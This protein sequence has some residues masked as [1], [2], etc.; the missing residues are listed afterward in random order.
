[1]QF[2]TI[3]PNGKPIVTRE[4][5]ELRRES[6][7]SRATDAQVKLLESLFVDNYLDFGGS[8]LMD[9]A[10]REIANESGSGWVPINVASDRRAGANW[11][12]WRTQQEL[13]GLRAKS[14][15]VVATNSYAKG[16][17]RNLTSHVIGKGNTYKV[18]PKDSAMP[19]PD[20]ANPNAQAPNL[21]PLVDATQA[22]VDA[23]LKSN[24][25]NCAADPM[26]PSK[27]G[28][29]REQE[30]YR[31]VKR[32]GEAILQFFFL[33]GR[34]Q[35]GRG[36]VDRGKT[37]V[38]FIEPACIVDPPGAT[39]Q[40]GWFLGLRHRV[41][42]YEDLEDVLEYHVLYSDPTL[43]NVEQTESPMGK[44]I[45]AAEIVHITNPD[46]DAMLGR[47]TP[48]FVYDTFKAFYRA[49]KLQQ[50]ISLGATIRACTAEMWEWQLATQQ[51]IG[52]LAGGQGT[53]KQNQQTGATEYNQKVEPGMIRHGPA[54][55]KLVPPVQGMVQE[56]L[57]AAQ[58]DLRQAASAGC[59]PEYMVSADASNA[60]YASTKEAGTPFVRYAELEQEYF[61]G[62]F[63]ACIWKAVWWAV[64]CGNLPKEALTLLDI[65]VK[66]A[67]VMTRDSLEVAQEDQ[68]LI[69]AG[70]KDRATASA[71]RGY[72]PDSVEQANAEYQQKNGGGMGM[73]VPPG[74]EGQP[75]MGGQ[76]GSPPVDP[77]R[78]LAAK[79]AVQS[80]E[81]FTPE[82]KADL[83]RLL[84][85]FDETK[86]KRDHGKFAT[87]P[88]G[89]EGS[90]HDTKGPSLDTMPGNAAEMHDKADQIA[91]HASASSEKLLAKFA[92]P[93]KWLRAKTD[94]FRAK[95]TERYGVKG[96][97][98]IMAAGQVITW[99][100]TIGAPIA[101]GLPIIVPPGGGLLT[102]LAVAGMVEAYKKIRGGG[103]SD[104][105]ES[106]EPEELTAEQIT[107]AAVALVNELLAGLAEQ[108]GSDSDDDAA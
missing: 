70:I 29:T 41:E 67:K 64:Q 93:A 97:A 32:D 30:T 71:E 18:K 39:V 33:S 73:Q 80:M 78:S 88:G 69:Q 86:V 27:I 5:L 46:E 43:E 49:G 35:G 100:I 42:P 16:Y 65:E 81:S 66:S 7:M 2:T 21:D 6:L 17:L 47:G 12:I 95:L 102:S 84:E 24:R 85:S 103:K 106:S 72:D 61:N 3:M 60:N 105:K 9:Q 58:G 11:P 52:T 8:D 44:L 34:E 22:V 92:A 31:R 37:F 25:W 56:N 55:R 20:P 68:I 4:Q 98:A 101:T 45:D 89:S 54:N 38:R 28:P 1:M 26:Q 96:A 13:S 87:K 74:Q 94:Q 59:A 104:V 57:D 79:S 50:A 108:V 99:G 23:F 82:Q 107:E 14:R 76:P 83:I 90:P 36:D 40:E 91:A 10:R 19:K 63:L 15:L 53:P 48:E 77:R 62:A 75:G 51:Q